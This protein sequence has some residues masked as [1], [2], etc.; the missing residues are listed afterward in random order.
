MTH[1][2]SFPFPDTPFALSTAN[3]LWWLEHIVQVIA[4][5]RPTA[6]VSPPKPTGGKC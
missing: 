5:W 6:P 3:L 1:D 4:D 2:R